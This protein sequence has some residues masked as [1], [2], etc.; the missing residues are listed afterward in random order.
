MVLA[1]EVEAYSKNLK[2]S[3]AF[4][5]RHDLF[6]FGMGLEIG[7]AVGGV[8]KGNFRKQG[9][10]KFEARVELGGWCNRCSKAVRKPEAR[11]ALGGWYN[12]RTKAHCKPEA[13][14]GL[15]GWCNPC[16]KALCKPEARVGL[17]GWCNP[18]R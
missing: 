4:L 10:H 16:S 5:A 14:V 11:V 3:G 6:D 17:G 15:G 12:S 9:S 1:P 8:A 13:R 18:C 7:L 2:H